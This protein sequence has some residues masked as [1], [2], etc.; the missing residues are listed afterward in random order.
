MSIKISLKLRMSFF[1]CLAI[2]MFPVSN[3]A[4]GGI[5]GHYDEVLG[6]IGILVSFALLLKGKIEGNNKYI[7]IILLA[8][9]IIGFVSNRFSGLMTQTRPILVDMLALWKIYAVYLLFSFSAAR[10]GAERVIEGLQL[11]AKATILFVT[12][13]SLLRFVVDIGVN[14]VYISTSETKFGFFWQ[15]AIQTGWLLFG[16][17]IIIAA[18]KKNSTKL[19]IKYMTIATIAM[20]QTESALVL[21]WL[22]SSIALM[23]LIKENKKFKVRYMLLL[24]AG[25]VAFSITDIMLYSDYEAVRMKFLRYAVVTAKT[26][27]PF[28]SGFATYGTD[29]AA[30]Y[31]SQLYVKYGWENT[32]ALGRES[33]YLNDT[34]FAGIIG[35]F[36]WIGMALYVILLINLFRNFNTVRYDKTVRALLL[37]TVITIGVVMI[38]SASAKSMM[39]AYMFAVLGV[40][41]ACKKPQPDAV[42]KQTE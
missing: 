28:G 20:L 13:V 5:L 3:L 11:I 6:M 41:N 38:G 10:A 15:N 2:V 32:W 1:V 9:T 21:C 7:C 19:F 29:M 24:T 18:S 8:I 14:I 31:Y 40:A 12:F 35:Q 39:G 33:T 25:V 30:K 23:V 4:G 26:Y 34:F 22:F 27:F 16:C 42:R 37:A 17:L 36:G